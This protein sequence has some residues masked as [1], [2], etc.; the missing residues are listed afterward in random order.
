M[1]ERLASRRHRGFSDRK[2][3]ALDD[4]IKNAVPAA[5][6]K[7]SVTLNRP[8][9]KADPWSKIKVWRAC[10]IMTIL[11]TPY[12][13]S[14]QSSRVIVRDRQSDVGAVWRRYRLCLQKTQIIIYNSGVPIRNSRL[15]VVFPT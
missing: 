7:S 10:S 5:R 9:C 2:R 11:L 6:Y 4:D 8:P 3:N 13:A 1:V 12:N 14:R 15:T